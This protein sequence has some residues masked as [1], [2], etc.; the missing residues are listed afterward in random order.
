MYYIFLIYFGEYY[1][2]SSLNRNGKKW[3]I[4]RNISFNQK[5]KIDKEHH[6]RRQIQYT[7]Y[8][9]LIVKMYIR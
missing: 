7:Y 5:G 4:K 3:G 1:F 8:G 6:K 2:L 9:L